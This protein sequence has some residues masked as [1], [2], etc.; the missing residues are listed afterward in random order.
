VS[1]RGPPLTRQ[2]R[3]ALAAAKITI[4][5]RHRAA[6]WG[7]Q[8]QVYLVSLGA[9]DSKDAITRIRAVLEAGGPFAAFSA[10]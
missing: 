2:S 3:D 7:G 9:R 4:I 10:A 1:F 8:V 5:D 6:G